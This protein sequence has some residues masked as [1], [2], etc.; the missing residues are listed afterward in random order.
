[1]PN[2]NISLNLSGAVFRC[3]APQPT[4]GNS[5]WKCNLW[6]RKSV[7][8]VAINADEKTIDSL[9]NQTAAANGGPIRIDGKNR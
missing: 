4:A 6:A 2:A 7:K 5:T 1:M 8:V 9:T 3:L